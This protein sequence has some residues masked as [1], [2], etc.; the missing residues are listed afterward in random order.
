[1]GGGGIANKFKFCC[2]CL[3]SKAAANAPAVGIAEK[4]N[5]GNY[6]IKLI[7]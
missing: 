2:C 7:L 5:N 1:M 6:S 3:R 4:K